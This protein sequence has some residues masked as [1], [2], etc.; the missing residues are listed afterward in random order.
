MAQKG[1]AG[2]LFF[3]FS[4]KKKMFPKIY[5]IFM[6]KNKKKVEKKKNCGRP[7]GFNFNHPLYRKQ[8]FF[9]GQPH[10]LFAYGV[11]CRLEEFGVIWLWYSFCSIVCLLGGGGGGVQNIEIIVLLLFIAHIRH[12]L[13]I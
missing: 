10:A 11:G 5:N 12:K 1:A 8:N 13:E 3:Y 4:K 2:N 9:Y 7:T 6:E